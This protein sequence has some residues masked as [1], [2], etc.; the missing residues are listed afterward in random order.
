[1]W[2]WARSPAKSDVGNAP[3][4]AGALEREQGQLGDPGAVV[5]ALWRALVRWRPGAP[6]ARFRAWPSRPVGRCRPDA[7]GSAPG[8]RR[9]LAPGSPVADENGGGRGGRGR[10]P[11]AADPAA[12]TLP[13]TA[14]ALLSL[15]A[16][17]ETCQQSGSRKT[18]FGKREILQK[19][20]RFR[21]GIPIVTAAASS[22]RRACFRAS[23]QPGG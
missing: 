22:D 17:D 6:R 18:G 1:M 5:T 23:T 4:I 16:R 9:E 19:L 13:A 15:D 12:R 2:T 20:Q 21:D 10:R 7:R 3:R 14:G 11:S 8:Q